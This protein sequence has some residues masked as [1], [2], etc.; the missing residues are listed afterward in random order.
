MKRLRLFFLS[1]LVATVGVTTA[2]AATFDGAPTSPLPFNQTSES[3]NYDVQVHERGSLTSLPAINAQHGPDCSA[4]P[5]S[6]PNTS[7]EGAVY[8]CANHIMTAM[9]GPE[10]GLIVLTPNQML[11][12]SA[13]GTVSFDVSTERMSVRDWWDVTVSPFMDAQALPLLSDLSQGVDLQNPNRNAVVIATD[14]GEAAPNLKVMQNGVQTSYG[15]P[16]WAG[17]PINAGILAGTNQAATR[18]PFRLTLTTTHVRFERLPTATGAAEVFIDQNIPALN[19][20]SGVVQIGHHSYTPTK[21]GACSADRTGARGTLQGILDGTLDPITLAAKSPTPA[22]LINGRASVGSGVLVSSGA[23]G[24]QSAA[25]LSNYGLGTEVASLA[26]DPMRD[27]LQ[28]MG[29]NTPAVAA[30]VVD[31]QTINVREVIRQKVG[32]AMGSDMLLAY[33]ES[34]VPGGDTPAFPLPAISDVVGVGDL[35]IEPVHAQQSSTNCSTWHWDNIAVSPA[36]PF[37]IQRGNE[38]LS[39][40]GIVTFPSAPSGAF[41][42]FSALCKPVVNGVGLSPMTD[43]G[44]REHA[45]SYMVAI[46]AFS[47]SASLSFIQDTVGTCNAKDFSVWALQGGSAPTA[48]PAP[49]CVPISIALPTKSR[50]AVLVLLK[51]SID[52]IEGMPPLAVGLNSV[53]GLM[54]DSAK[55]VHAVSNGFQVIGPN[56]RANTAEMVEGQTVRDW[57]NQGLVGPTVSLAFYGS[58]VPGTGKNAI[59]SYVALGSPEPAGGG[60]FDLWPKALGFGEEGGVLVSHDQSIPCSSP[61]PTPTPTNTPVPPTATATPIPPTPT[62]TPTPANYRCQIRNANGTWTTVWTQVGGKAC[63]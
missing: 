38:R 24:N 53:T 61:S 26:I 60:L 36:I 18:Q 34:T 39:L 13:G 56:A 44:H 55:D 23:V 52:H 1:I 10:Y 43:S 19:F 16:G 14:N 35:A 49:T 40:G 9:N 25:L 22:A 12:F 11:D 41:L 47:T 31:V 21:D 46:P 15:P 7:F 27:R 63:P 29:I 37:S 57:P 3:A 42:R 28:M 32:V 45:A 48:S 2:L 17:T 20:T 33:R 30:K 51:S 54:T 58:G 6:H 59:A 8:Q 5:A 62:R 50:D 4:P